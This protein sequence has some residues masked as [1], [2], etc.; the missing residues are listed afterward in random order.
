VADLA[1]QSFV[2]ARLADF[3]DWRVLKAGAGENP[4]EF[5]LLKLREIEPPLYELKEQLFR[6][7]ARDFL[8]LAAS[9]AADAGSIQQFSFLLE[10]YLSPGDFVD[11][12]FGLDEAGLREA[13]A[14]ERLCGTLKGLRVYRL[15]EEESRPPEKRRKS[16]ESLVGEFTRRLGYDALAR[17]L[18]RRAITPRRLRFVLRRAQSNVGEYCTVLRH[19]RGPE[20]AFTPFMTPRVEALVASTRRFLQGPGLR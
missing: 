2:L 3:C 14:R 12:V 8:A 6:D 11:A 19:P 15:L 4:V 20:D 16:W 10:R 1:L 7:A 5:L 9:G 17:I 13:A 18:A